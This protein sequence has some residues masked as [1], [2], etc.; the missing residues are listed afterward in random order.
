MERDLEDIF[1]QL[2]LIVPEGVPTV[3]EFNRRVIKSRHPVYGTPSYHED[4]KAWFR[5]LAAPWIL[6]KRKSD[7]DVREY[8]PPFSEKFCL[9]PMHADQRRI[10]RLLEDLAWDPK[11]GSFIEVPGL[12]VLLRQLAGDPHAVLE[13]AQHGTSALAKMVAE[14][15]RWEL[16]QCSSAKAERL[17]TDVDLVLAAE[18]K[19]V[20]FT[21]FGQT[22]LP[23]VHARLGGRPVFTYHG[24]MTQRE[25]DHQKNAFMSCS[26]GAILLSSDAGSRGINLPCSYIIEYDV[27]QKHSTRQQRAGRGH[28]LGHQDPVTFYTYVLEDTIESYSSVRTLLDRNETQDFILGDEGAPNFT[29]ADNRREMFAAAKHRRAA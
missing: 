19:A 17:C 9:I 22:V 10:Y 28:R 15:M 16:Q 5:D 2:R 18:A 26:G 14:E 23:A 6:R 4:G 13:A 8:F 25:R 3:T 12:N 1:N 24:E 7:P 20:V 21:H 27:A 11:D 29:T